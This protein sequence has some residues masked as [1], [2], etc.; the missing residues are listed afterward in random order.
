MVLPMESISHELGPVMTAAG[1]G[2]KEHGLGLHWSPHLS[3]EGP[4][5]AHL[6]I[7]CV[8]PEVRQLS[9]SP[10]HFL[11]LFLALSTPM[12]R[13]GS[14]IRDQ[15]EGLSPCRPFLHLHLCVVLYIW[16]GQHCSLLD[17]GPARWQDRRKGM[18]RKGRPGQ[19][20][21]SV[22]ALL[23]LKGIVSWQGPSWRTATNHV[24]GFNVPSCQV[25]LRFLATEIFSV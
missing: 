13:G 4:D 21:S 6:Q 8:R 22:L 10:H 11:P 15:E 7:W 19:A 20:D 2:G 18:G 12:Q 17:I 1:V 3:W 9:V 25:N 5:Q 16:C 14:T 24:L 23:G